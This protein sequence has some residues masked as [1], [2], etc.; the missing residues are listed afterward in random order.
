MKCKYCGSERVVKNGTKHGLQ[1]Y[2]CKE[3]KRAWTKP[4]A[5]RSIENERRAVV[6]YCLGFGFG[7]IAKLL[8]YSKTT[9]LNWINRFAEEHRENPVSKAEITC[10][11]DDARRFVL[12]KRKNGEYERYVGEWPDG[13]ADENAGWNIP[14]VFRDSII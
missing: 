9:I 11:F 2:L 3:C 13:A 4:A 7:A 12:S 10:E 1:N 14:A 5:R 6:L 8:N